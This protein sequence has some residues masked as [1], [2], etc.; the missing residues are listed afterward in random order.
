MRVEAIK[1]VVLEKFV[2]QEII[3]HAAFQRTLC[4]FKASKYN[5]VESA[6][7]ITIREIIENSKTIDGDSAIRIVDGSPKTEILV[8]YKARHVSITP[9]RA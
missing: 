2:K 8:R 5:I 6:L 3:E 1:S 4:V 9:S 7:K